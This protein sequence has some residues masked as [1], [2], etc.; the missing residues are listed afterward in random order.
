MVSKKTTKSSEG[1]KL[2]LVKKSSNKKGKLMQLESHRL[3]LG[4]KS[5]R[6][7]VISRTQRTSWTRTRLSKT[8]ISSKKCFNYKNTMRRKYRRKKSLLLL[9]MPK[10]RSLM[11][12]KS[13]EMQF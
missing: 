3:M 6:K 5:V 9:K 10:S 7:S 2:S 8:R 12:S 4:T 1:A 11:S 13:R